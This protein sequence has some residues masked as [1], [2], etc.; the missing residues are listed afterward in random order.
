MKFTER[1]IRYFRRP[2]TDDV[3]KAIQAPQADEPV[4]ELSE[5]AVTQERLHDAESTLLEYR[6]G[7]TSLEERIVQNRE[8]FRLRH[9]EMMRRKQ[10]P[11][12]PEPASAWLL[13]AIMNKHADAMDNYPKPNVLPREE[14]DKQH[15]EQLSSI[16]PVLLEQN[17]FEQVYNDAWWYKL[18][19]G[20]AVY[21]VFWDSSKL[22][23]LGDISVR[24]IDMLNLFWEP[25]ITDIQKSRNLFHVELVDA[26]IL[27]QQY[28]Q[29]QGKTA[30]S[31]ITVKE[32]FHDD[33]IDNSKK[34][35]VIDWY[36]KLNQNGKDVLHYVK[37]ANLEVLYASEDDPEYA[38]RGFYDHGMYPFEFDVLFPEPDSPAGFG[39][40]D[41]GKSP[42][43][44]IDKL[45]QSI[46][47][48]AVIGSRTR[49]WVRE[50]GKI[51]E[52][53]FA[54]LTK[55][56]VHYT[57]V[58]APEE[59]IS[60]I[61]PPRLDPMFE[62][63][64]QNK[65]EELKETTGNRDFNQGGTTGQVTAA[66]AI[67]ALQEAGS[68]LS[69]DMNK[70]AYRTHAQIC[71][72][73]I[74]LIR[75]F[76]R[77]DRVFRITG[78]NGDMQFTRFNGQDLAAQEQGAEFGIDAGYRLPVFDIEVTSQRSSPFSVEAHNERAKEL[79][80]MGF[81]NPEMADQALI[82][83]EMMQFEGIENIRQKISQ[84]SML[85]KFFQ[86]IMPVMMEMAQRLDMLQGTSYTPQVA[87]LL[88]MPMMPM[89]GGNG[90]EVETSSLGEVLPH[91][92]AGEARARIARAATPQ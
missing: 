23:G 45:D 13:N 36:Y 81:F 30:A 5:S 15:A 21:G 73:C 91:S 8:W 2:R 74:E 87:Q 69:R 25:G 26:D 43:I 47:K 82:A 10:N 67:A 34:I 61:D 6:R 86:Q 63:V 12:D 46:L 54:D 75:Q 39:Y 60:P 22:N 65:I 48:T 27:E 78:P 59:F 83:L 72:L 57:G 32:Y 19:T 51:N 33:T 50:E 14:S 71:Y 62:A 84:N 7:K 56:F 38:D 88:G 29:M 24:R 76:Y 92:Y 77:E 79:Y 85:H 64:R 18:I 55:D 28:P 44:Y 58:N 9:W 80:G 31:S 40:V 17:E 70:S 1:V 37:F 68:K 42:Q 52:E 66:S 53:E 3:P 90:K 20:T 41:I 89:P 49:F 11:G 4:K 16:L 35:A